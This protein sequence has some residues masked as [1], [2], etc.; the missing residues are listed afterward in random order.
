ML[1]CG[2]W[3]CKEWASFYSGLAQKAIWSSRGTDHDGVGWK[4]PAACGTVT[5]ETTH[6]SCISYIP[7]EPARRSVPVSIGQCWMPALCPHTSHNEVLYEVAHAQAQEST[8]EQ[9]VNAYRLI[10]IFFVQGPCG[11]VWYR[12]LCEVL[13]WTDI[14]Y[15]F[16]FLRRLDCV[17]SLLRARVWPAIVYCRLRLSIMCCYVQQSCYNLSF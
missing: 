3:I 5:K 13:T 12:L 7:P 4:L 15:R 6:S 17:I 10:G 2:G 1:D 14:L 11:V 9:P 16:L 8:C